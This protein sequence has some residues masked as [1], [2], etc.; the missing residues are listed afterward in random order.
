MPETKPEKL[1]PQIV[2]STS[3]RGGTATKMARAAETVKAPEPPATKSQ[4]DSE[5]LSFAADPMPAMKAGPKFGNEKAERSSP[6]QDSALFSNY[7]SEHAK[8]GSNPVKFVLAGAAV[9]VLA[10]AVFG[11]SRIG[12]HTSTTAAAAPATEASAPLPA[13]SSAPVTYASDAPPALTNSTQETSPKAAADT[14]NSAASRATDDNHRKD[15]SVATKQDHKSDAQPEPLSIKTPDAS[16]TK[17]PVEV[18]DVQAPTLM[19]GV[20]AG[21]MPDLHA[22]VVPPKPDFP[23][24]SVVAPKLLNGPR[25]VFPIGAHALRLKGDTVVLNAKV[26]TNGKVGDISVVRGQPVFVQAVKEAVKRWQYTPAQLNNQPTEATI[27]IV[28]KFGEEQ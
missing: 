26:L 23:T 6:G 2:R 24:A 17:K 12:H 11:F 20:S 5:L 10:G 4:D 27:E 15:Q 14:H 18:S 28:F 19:A 1:G 25:P 3:A 22:T 7:A 13:S 8:S 9:L 21:K 16:L